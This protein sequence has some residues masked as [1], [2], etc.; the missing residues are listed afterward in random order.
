[1]PALVHYLPIATTILSSVFTVILF[2]HWRRKPEALY[3]F[4]WMAG[5]FVYGLGTLTE[6]LTTLFGWHLVTFKSWY[7]AGALLGGAPLAQ[8][9][10]YLLIARKT[11]HIFTAIL[12]I[13]VLIAAT[14]VVLS[15]VEI[16]LVENH[17]LSGSVFTWQW[18]RLF[19]PF[20]NLYA[21]VFL[22]GGAIYSA[23]KYFRSQGTSARFWGNASIAFGAILPG[24]GGSFTRAGFV[25]VLYVTE[26]VGLAFI[27]AG[28]HL[29]SRDTHQSIHTSQQTNGVNPYYR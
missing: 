16:A 9:T 20:I 24:I 7:I 2:K 17:R 15:P 28:Y 4:W 27:W 11:A 13:V 5:V 18:V 8:G 10:V 19:S 21:V 14:S 1:M 25:E 3:L 26:L 22:V 29:I 12:L 6:S 23:V